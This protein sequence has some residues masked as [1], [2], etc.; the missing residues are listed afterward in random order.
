MKE[1]LEDVGGDKAKLRKQSDKL[2][3]QLRD[4]QTDKRQATLEAFHQLEAQ[5]GP[6]QLRCEELTRALFESENERSR[7]E[8]QLRSRQAG[9]RATAEWV[10]KSLA[11]EVSPRGVSTSDAVRQAY[12]GLEQE[13]A[14]LKERHARCQ[15]L[16]R[17][18]ERQSDRARK[19]AGGSGAAGRW[20]G[21]GD[22]EGESISE[23][24]LQR[25]RE[26]FSQLEADNV[27]L[28]T[29]SAKLKEAL[30][31]Q[32]AEASA[33]RK[34]VHRLQSENAA[35]VE[36]V[37]EPA[38]GRGTELHNRQLTQELENMSA[39]QVRLNAEH[40]VLKQQAEHWRTAVEQS[41]LA[42]TRVEKEN[43]SLNKQLFNFL[44]SL[45][46]NGKV[47]MATPEPSSEVHLGALQAHVHTLQQRYDR[48]ERE[49][50]RVR[51]EAQVMIVALLCGYLLRF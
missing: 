11:R 43:Q 13:N 17:E 41:D 30:S 50:D 42:K 8:R 47:S 5:M 14:R 35:L 25:L 37:A 1:L 27:R 39:S 38:Q 32:D 16:L 19:V 46:S 48:I 40:Q 20:A 9:D 28:E 18:A 34:H 44:S 29:Q 10:E 12:T 51:A 24:F 36:S 3:R 26:S 22:E 15:S 33:L 2:N 45:S 23:A 31:A 7:M 49:S 4:D 21:R 6:L